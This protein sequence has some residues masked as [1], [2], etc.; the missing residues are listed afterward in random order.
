[1][2]FAHV[3]I[4]LGLR[5]ML[6][7]HQMLNDRSTYE[8]TFHWLLSHFKQNPH[9]ITWQT[10]SFLLF[11]F[12]F[13]FLSLF[14]YVFS[15]NS[16]SGS[17]PTVD[18]TGIVMWMFLIFAVTYKPQVT[19]FQFRSQLIIIGT[20]SSPPLGIKPGALSMLH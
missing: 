4:F 3:G 2:L 15:F 17:L 14:P 1:M 7:T 18:L 16:D 5:M 8:L 20:S 10:R 6:D 12:I 9:F 13:I 19:F 11:T